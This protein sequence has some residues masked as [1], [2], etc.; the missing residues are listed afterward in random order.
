M[1]RRQAIRGIIKTVAIHQPN[2]LPW[3]GFFD[4]LDRCDTFV[5]LDDVQLA[6][7]SYTTS[8]CV[9]QARTP[10]R[11]T[12]P[13][14]HVGT[15]HLPIREAVID[16]S[17][18]LLVKAARTVET[19]YRRCPY[20]REY[21]E[22]VVQI[23]SDSEQRLAPLNIRLLRF[24]AES[25]GISTEK[26]RLQSHLDASGK[27]SQLMA[28]LTRA[29]GHCVYLSG[30]TSPDNGPPV[31]KTGTA[32]DYNDPAVFAAQGVEL[33][34]QNFVHPTY[35]QGSAAFVP[36]LSILDMLVRLG[37]DTLPLIRQA[38]GRRIKRDRE[39]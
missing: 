5:L 18:R 29:L 11:L 35:K 31:E 8:V 36:G 19:C 30:G 7:R 37:S 12:V 17:T 39:D 15:Q 23:L 1:S 16:H 4:K 6:R 25:L 28:S 9:L 32:A 27:K 21:G 13:V 22:P 14:R 10:V 3:A 33:V 26:I 20:W 34:Y 24:L 2:F 38:N